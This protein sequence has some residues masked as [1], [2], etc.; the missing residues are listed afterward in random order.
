MQQLQTASVRKQI[1]LV[2]M[3]E[4][5]VRFR[6]ENQTKSPGSSPEKKLATKIAKKDSFGAILA[7]KKATVDSRL[8]CPTVFLIINR[9][10]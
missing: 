5:L 4:F 6:S 7:M 1:S 10:F 2:I 9:S 8:L 3:T